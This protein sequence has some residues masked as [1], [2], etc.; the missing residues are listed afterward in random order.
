MAIL[1]AKPEDAAVLSNVG[2]ISD[3]KIRSTAKS[4]QILSSSLYANKIRAII[5]ELSC[6]AF[7]SHVAAG[8]QDVPFYVH[9]PTYLEPYFYVRDFG[10]G[11]T[12]DQV[13]RKSV[14]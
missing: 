12:H 9:F 6:N 2:A 5:R 1:N 11:L 10:I 3:F 7:D 8:K 13:D 4:F 14:V